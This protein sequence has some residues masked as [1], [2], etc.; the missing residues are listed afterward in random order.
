M[1][2]SFVKVYSIV[3]EEKVKVYRISAP[4]TPD[5][6]FY[7]TN[8]IW[9]E[10]IEL[11]VYCNGIITGGENFVPLIPVR[12]YP[13]RCS[14]SDIILA[15]EKKQIDPTKSIFGEPDIAVAANR[16][17]ADDIS[18]QQELWNKTFTKNGKDKNF[19]IVKQWKTNPGLEGE[20]DVEFLLYYAKGSKAD[21]QI[22]GKSSKLENLV[23]HY[24][25]AQTL[26]C[27]PAGT[28]QRAALIEELKELAPAWST[29]NPE[30]TGNKRCGENSAH[31]MHPNWALDKSPMK[32]W[33]DHYEEP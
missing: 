7:D 24:V 31:R 27:C 14:W 9:Q 17:L 8:S 11:K 25:T 19:R 1:D 3:Q 28:N 22:I 26:F 10:Q 32:F 5:G 23:T 6:K 12:G 33:E 2:T 21:W 20:L 4:G 30:H 13:E 15:L 16:W 18:H 29:C